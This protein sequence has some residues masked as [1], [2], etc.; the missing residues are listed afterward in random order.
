MLLFQEQAH[1]RDKQRKDKAERLARVHGQNREK[2][3]M[4]FSKAHSSA[5][6]ANVA[7]MLA[8]LNKAG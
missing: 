2:T 8:L 5:K 3:R 4:A 6:A 1:N 7:T